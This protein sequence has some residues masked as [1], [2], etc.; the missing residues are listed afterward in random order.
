MT[1]IM[2]LVQNHC[3]RERK[4]KFYACQMLL[5]SHYLANVIKT[6]TGKNVS[7]WIT[8]YTILEAKRLLAVSNKTIQQIS[9]DLCFGDAVTFGKFFRRNT[10][11]TPTEFRLLEYKRNE[12]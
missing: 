7:W 1:V 6:T 5:S 12:D 11:M 3:F 10:G 9:I 4:T 2:L 8:K